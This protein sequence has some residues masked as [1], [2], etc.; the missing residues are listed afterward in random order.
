M[1]TREMADSTQPDAVRVDTMANWN[2]ILVNK[3]HDADGRQFV[4]VGWKY[5]KVSYYSGEYPKLK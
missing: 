5:C 1:S 2:N 4:L 3:L